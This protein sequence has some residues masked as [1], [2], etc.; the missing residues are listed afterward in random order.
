MHEDNSW[1]LDLDDGELRWY[2]GTQSWESN[3]ET[4]QWQRFKSG[5]L[6]LQ[7]LRR[8]YKCIDLLW[9]YLSK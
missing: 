4:S 5:F 7:P 2:S 3:S 1:R 6:Q 9:Y 8:T